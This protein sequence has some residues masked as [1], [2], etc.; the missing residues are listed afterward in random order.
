MSVMCPLKMLQHEMSPLLSVGSVEP[1]DTCLSSIMS[2][3]RST[4]CPSW[5]H[6]ELHILIP[7][8]MVPERRICQKDAFLPPPTDDEQLNI[9]LDKAI[10]EGIIGDLLIDPDDD[11][12]ILT[13]RRFLSMFKRQDHD[14]SLDDN[15]QQEVEN[16]GLEYILQL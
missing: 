1:L 7:A 16:A 13:R 12:D 15:P 6:G 4:T 5:L 14:E 3:P 9:W 11:E 2:D 10:V 8:L